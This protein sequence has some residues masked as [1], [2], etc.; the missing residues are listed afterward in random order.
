MNKLINN[1]NIYKTYI[2]TYDII[3]FQA[4]YIK[5]NLKIPQ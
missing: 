1:V 4:N 2:K 5:L 3:L